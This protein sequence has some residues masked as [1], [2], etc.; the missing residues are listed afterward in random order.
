LGARD[1]DSNSGGPILIFFIP[2]KI[3][4]IGPLNS[5]QTWINSRNKKIKR[6]GEA[7]YLL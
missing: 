1:P 4:C 7:R 6:S 5:G 3:I 2:D